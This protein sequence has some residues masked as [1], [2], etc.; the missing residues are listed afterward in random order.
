MINLVVFASGGGSN[1]QKIIKHFKLHTSVKVALVI[2]GNPK[3][4]VISMAEHHDI[5]VH[6]ISKS[7]FTDEVSMLSLLHSYQIDYVI[8]AGFLWLCPPFLTRNFHNKIL[9]IHPSL[10]PKYGGKGMYGHFV[11][12]AVRDAREN[13]SGCTIHLV[14]NMYDEGQIIFQAV[15]P[16]TAEMNPSDIAS[17]V[18]RLEHAYYATVIENYIMRKAKI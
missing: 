12:E 16:L 6:V 14:N 3:A 5:P 9:N 13:E 18:L 17:A 15:C 10:L 1:A 2:T 11:H 8:L 7:T 4:G